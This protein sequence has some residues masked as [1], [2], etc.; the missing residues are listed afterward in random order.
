MV[1]TTA[2][3]GVDWFTPQKTMAC[4]LKGTLGPATVTLILKVPG[5]GFTTYQICCVPWFESGFWPKRHRDC[6]PYMTWVGVFPP[7]FQPS[8]NTRINMEFA[9]AA[10]V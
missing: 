1:S 5:V 3:Q 9:Q 8:S 6:V 2:P 4:M 10:T 7:P